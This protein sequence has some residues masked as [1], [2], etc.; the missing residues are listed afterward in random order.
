MWNLSETKMIVILAC[1]SAAILV[2]I[3]VVVIV[4]CLL[5][6]TRRRYNV[7]QAASR[8]DDYSTINSRD[9]QMR[10]QV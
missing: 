1:L 4:G 6:V 3:I 10:S 7:K 9:E 2:L 8:S 5:C